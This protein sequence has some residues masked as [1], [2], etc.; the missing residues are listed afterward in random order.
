MLQ[1]SGSLKF[2]VKGSTAE[3]GGVILG[4]ARSLQTQRVA[5][6]YLAL[7]QRAQGLVLL[8][9]N[10][11]SSAAPLSGYVNSAVARAESENPNYGRQMQTRTRP[12]REQTRVS[13]GSMSHKPARSV[14]AGEQSA[15]K[16]IPL[17]HRVLPCRSS[18][19]TVRSTMER[20]R[21]TYA[22]TLTYYCGQTF[23]PKL[24]VLPSSNVPMN[25]R[26]DIRCATRTLP[27]P[28]PSEVLGAA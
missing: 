7:V 10:R 14:D 5:G 11:S 17:P 4:F 15:K 26:H 28:A 16:S 25:S 20:Y 24:P 23:S 3:Q 12:C 21:P 1:N 18:V 22:Q 6:P 19:H 27:P 8:T 9:A 2:L 13:P